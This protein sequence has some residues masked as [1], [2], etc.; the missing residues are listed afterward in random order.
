MEPRAF[1][2]RLEQLGFLVHQALMDSLER[3]EDPE[4]AERREPLEPVEQLV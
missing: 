3:Q 1:L 4:P 2:E